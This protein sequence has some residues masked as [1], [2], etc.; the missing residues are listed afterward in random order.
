MLNGIALIAVITAGVTATFI[1]RARR[2]R[3]GYE[4]PETILHDV[5][6]SLPDPASA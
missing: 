4:D 6:F 2:E 1:E 5:A 3:S